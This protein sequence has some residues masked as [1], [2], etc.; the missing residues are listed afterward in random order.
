MP[1][2]IAPILVRGTVRIFAGEAGAGWVG[3][4]GGVTSWGEETL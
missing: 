3:R 1:A 4:S 2:H